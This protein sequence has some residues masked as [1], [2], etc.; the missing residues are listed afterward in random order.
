MVDRT[1]PLTT[2]ELAAMKA[3]LAAA[4]TTVA[5]LCSGKQRWRMNVPAELTDPDLVIS[6][7]L[8][9]MARLIGE[10]ERLQ[11]EN[12]ELQHLYDALS[13]VSG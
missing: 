12:A 5:E 3:L 1:V 11:A 8:S 13:E 7:A 6:A 9:G 2:D 10:V 4:D